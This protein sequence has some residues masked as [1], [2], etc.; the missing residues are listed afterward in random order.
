MQILNKITK[1]DG[2]SKWAIGFFPEMEPHF[3]QKK[4]A[5]LVINGS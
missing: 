5:P 2:R 1:I 3:H 4:V